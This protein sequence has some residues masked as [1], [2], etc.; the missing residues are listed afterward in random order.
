MKP[1]FQQK[2]NKMSERKPK[3]YTELLGKTNRIVEGTVING[4]IISQADF[5]LDGQLKG[6]FTT[7]GKIV[8]GPTGSIKGDVICQNADIEG[9]F[10][11]ILKVEEILNV[12]SKA[13]IS[14]EVSCGKLSVQPG[15]DFSASCVM[16]PAHKK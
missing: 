2:N 3:V 8:I 9:T 13:S 7:S 4:D 10:D 12:K 11:G 1:L 15:A 14:G 16:Q 5:R 6:N